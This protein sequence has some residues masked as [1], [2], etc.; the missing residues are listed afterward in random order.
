VDEAEVDMV[1][2]YD[3]GGYDHA[4]PRNTLSPPST[5][6]CTTCARQKKCLAPRH[7]PY[8]SFHLGADDAVRNATRFV[9]EG[10]GMVKIKRRRNG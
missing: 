2:V 7:M 9:K 10:G 4:R 6:C 8:G 1:L 5:R 3:S